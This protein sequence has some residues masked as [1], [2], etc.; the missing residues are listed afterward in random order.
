MS[1]LGICSGGAWALAIV[2]L[3]FPR[4]GGGQHHGFASGMWRWVGG[5]VGVDPPSFGFEKKPLLTVDS[6]S[7]DSCCQPD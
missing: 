6:L 4:P 7:L 1:L 3:W 5:W 2:G